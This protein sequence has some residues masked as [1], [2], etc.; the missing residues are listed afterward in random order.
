MKRLVQILCA[1]VLFSSLAQA[2][3]QSIKVVGSS[4]VYPFTTVVAE[5][6]GKDTKYG[7]PI[8]ESTG[9]GGGMK[10]FCA[11]IGINT[12]SVTNASRAIKSKEAAL[13]EKN[14]VS[15]V[16]F[17]VGNDGIA[18]ANS[19]E[20]PKIDITKEQL[21]QAM[22]L[23]GPQPK[24]WSDIDPSLPNYDIKIMTPPPTSG[25]RDAWN[26]LVMKK[27]CPA[28]ILKEKGKKACYQLR[29]DGGVIEVGENDTLLIN[30][31]GG[32]KQL[33]AIFGFSYLDSSRDKVQAAKIE[34]S[35]ISLDSIQSYDYPI[36]RPLFIYF[37][38][39]HMDVV[40]GLQKFMKTYISKKAMGPRGY[41]MD[42]GLVPL[43]KA[44]FKE[45]KKRTKLK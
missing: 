19:V 22:A 9:T 17:K 8:V 35:V 4:T 30:K 12:P 20:G 44:T 13:C 33:F 24:K 43:D 39:E 14:G 23:L 38:K 6:F 7:T 45:M 5:R 42:L 26:S 29:E 36:A 15:F 10:L 16:E 18:F 11:G 25:T 40:P 27:G 41:L 3:E 21:W 34:G 28:D 31:M 1:V 2:A 32:D 37:K